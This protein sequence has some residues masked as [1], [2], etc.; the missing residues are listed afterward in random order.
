MGGTGGRL[1]GVDEDQKGLPS[2]VLELGERRPPALDALLLEDE[3]A[4]PDRM[5]LDEDL[6]RLACDEDDAF[7]EPVGTRGG[8]RPG[9]AVALV[10]LPTRCL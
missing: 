5:S 6:S 1:M 4:A 2:V 3:L 8:L 7:D 9:E 10:A